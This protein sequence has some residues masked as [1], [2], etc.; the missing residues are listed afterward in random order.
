MNEALQSAT[1]VQGQFG[2][3]LGDQCQ[4]FDILPLHI[5]KDPEHARGGL[6][7]TLNAHGVFYGSYETVLMKMENEFETEAL[8]DTVA[9]DLPKDSLVQ[10]TLVYPVEEQRGIVV[11]VES[12]NYRGQEIAALERTQAHTGQDHAEETYTFDLGEGSYVLHL[13]YE[14]VKAEQG[15]SY[16]S[17]Y[18]S[19]AAKKEVTKSCVEDDFDLKSHFQKE[20]LP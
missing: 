6:E 17:A 4:E 12:N 3:V 5:K 7:P 18:L 11:L 20:N 16:F 15:C 10:L 2:D 9:F 1:A 14:G 8:R 13:V 19:I